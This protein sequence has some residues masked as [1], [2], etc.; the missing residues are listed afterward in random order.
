MLQNKKCAAY[1]VRK[2]QIRQLEEGDVVFLYHNEHGIIAFG[3]AD[4][5]FDKSY[6]DGEKDQ[7]YSMKLK[8]FHTTKD[9]PL[10]ASEIKDITGNQKL[11]FGSTM[12]YIEKN[13]KKIKNELQN[14][15]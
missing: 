14:R 15:I 13:G 1:D 12:F 8:N 10:T 5:N 7:E 2:R 11:V 4:E 3:E 6:H 9:K